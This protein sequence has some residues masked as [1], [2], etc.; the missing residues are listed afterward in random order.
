MI[1]FEVLF[2]LHDTKRASAVMNKINVNLRIVSILKNNYLYFAV[3]RAT[4]YSL[5][6]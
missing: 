6:L 1:F 5:P 3:T 4:V 2:P